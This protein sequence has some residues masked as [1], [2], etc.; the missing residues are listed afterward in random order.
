MYSDD[1][2]DEL[3][4]MEPTWDSAMLPAPLLE[5]LGMVAGVSPPPGVDAAVL[6]A[7]A[8]VL[9]DDD[10]TALPSE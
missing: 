3:D 2:A 6:D 8:G 7:D 10:L 1:D 5:R 9:R 4:A